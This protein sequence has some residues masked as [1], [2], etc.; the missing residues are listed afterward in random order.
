MRTRL[1][2]TGIVLLALFA[3]G[4]GSVIAATLCPHMAQDHRCCPV[5]RNPAHAAHAHDSMK[6]TDGMGDMDMS[7]ASESA[8]AADGVVADS[9]AVPD[10]DCE[11]CMG[12]REVPATPVAATYVSLGR[13]GADAA[14]LRPAARLTELSLSFTP[15]VS[16]RQHAPPGPATTARHVLIGVFLI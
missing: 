7:G 10:G 8:D 3:G 14:P 6:H 15:P 2:S 11:H 9:L 5:E 1:L 13:Q 4:W 12:R 16:A